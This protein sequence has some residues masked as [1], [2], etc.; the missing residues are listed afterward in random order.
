MAGAVDG[1]SK[2]MAVRNGLEVVAVVG[3]EKLKVEEELWN[4]VLQ[5]SLASLRIQVCLM[6]P[7]AAKD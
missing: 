7:D 4:N 6:N 5:L 1:C 3:K 2:G